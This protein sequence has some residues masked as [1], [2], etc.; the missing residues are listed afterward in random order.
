MLHVLIRVA[1]KKPS[2]AYYNKLIHMYTIF[3][4]PAL[5]LTLSSRHLSLLQCSCT[6]SCGV[7]MPEPACC[8]VH[9]CR[10]MGSKVHPPVVPMTSENEG[11]GLSD[12]NAGGP[13]DPSREHKEEEEEI[14][15][16]TSAIV[17]S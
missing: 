13:D 10:E 1:R 6:C 4:K 9:V 14:R 17:S 7:C 3:A 8:L 15:A 11:C 5:I 2:S 16:P 12:L